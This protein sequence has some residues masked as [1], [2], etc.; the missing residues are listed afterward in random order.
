MNRSETERGEGEVPEFDWMIS[1]QK[2]KFIS[3]NN[4]N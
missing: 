2:R 1:N 4:K 3:L